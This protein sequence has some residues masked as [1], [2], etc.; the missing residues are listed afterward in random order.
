M[1]PASEWKFFEGTEQRIK[2]LARHR[3]E[4][5]LALHAG[6]TPPW[7]RDELARR[8][9]TILHEMDYPSRVEAAF[10]MD[11]TPEEARHLELHRRWVL[12]TLF[13]THP[14][15][16]PL[17]TRIEDRVLGFVLEM[18]GRPF[19]PAARRNILHHE[20]DRARRESAYRAVLP[21]GEA[22]ED[23]LKELIRRRELLARSV[24]ETG[25]PSLA[26]HFHGRDR[27]EAVALLDEMERTTRSAFKEA[28]DAIARVLDVHEV[29]P[30]DLD[31]GLNR[32]SPVG[33][34]P[35]PAEQSLAA[36]R[37]QARRWNLNVDVP[38]EACDSFLGTRSVAVEV[39]GE[40]RVLLAGDAG[41]GGLRSTFRALGQ[42]LHHAHITT[43]RHFLE[44]E[45]PGLTEATGALFAGVLRDGGWLAKHLDVPARDIEEHQKAERFRRIVELRRRAALTTFENLVYARS[46]VEPGRLYFDVAEQLLQET[47][48]PDVV[49]PTHV[50]LALAPLHA[51]W[52]LHG[53]MVAA[54]VWERLT[55]DFAEPWRNPQV[56]PWLRDHVFAAGARLGESEKIEQATGSPPR[57]E[58]LFA[59]LEVSF[60]GPA[61]TES[62]GVP[63]RFVDEVFGSREP[64]NS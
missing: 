24:A 16:V 45:A 34:D 31:Y 23:D 38:V 36:A 5:L 49:W 50:G 13:E 61:L 58:P 1:I 47:R 22:L 20:P 17:L 29:L 2:H 8:T 18:D 4:N 62:E 3:A 42:A 55:R 57:P 41:Q 56:G 35:F 52:E 12:R 19:S 33:S 40:V 64:E 59:S 28:H 26:F 25:F 30:W 37:A 11:P 6:K 14:D 43:R 7:P 54:Q 51:Y 63:D 27:A 46:E 15:L 10:A 44:Q 9:A 53:E 39:P 32:L 48:R 21:L 60:S